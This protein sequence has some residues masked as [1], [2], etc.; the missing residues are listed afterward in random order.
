MTTHN[1]SPLATFDSAKH[2]FAEETGEWI[3][4]KYQAIM[5]QEWSSS[6]QAVIPE[7][8]A[9]HLLAGVSFSLFFLYF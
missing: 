1:I 3:V 5:L 6:E 8:L 2:P 9:Q 4:G 7:D